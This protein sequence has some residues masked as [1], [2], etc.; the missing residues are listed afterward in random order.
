MSGELQRLATHA[1]V[2]PLMRTH[3]GLVLSREGRQ[4]QT[5]LR[6]EAAD[7]MVKK[8]RIAIASDIAMDAM[9]SVKAVD[10]YRRTLAGN[11]EGLNSLLAQVELNH[12]GHV[13]RIQRGSAF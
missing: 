5:A 11:D 2:S 10:D 9:D 3:G 6:Q 12:V 8:A 13:T 1:E 4:L 7:G